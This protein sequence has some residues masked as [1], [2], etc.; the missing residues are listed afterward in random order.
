MTKTQTNAQFNFRKV[1][2]IPL[3][4][5]VL[6]LLLLSNAMAAFTR[7]SG[8]EEPRIRQVC[9][10]PS[11]P[12]FLAVASENGLYIS[13]NGG[14][15]F[16]KKAVF[17]DETIN[18]LFLSSGMEP[19]VY[20]AGSRNGYKVESS[21]KRIFTAKENEELYFIAGYNGFLYAGT[22][23]GLYF[24][25]E[26]PINWQ[27]LPA[28]GNHAVYSM[29]DSGNE[30]Y[31]ACDDG[32]YLYR[33]DHTLIRLFSPPGN[34]EEEARIPHQITIDTMTPSRLWLCTG[35]GV[36]SSVDRGRTW[37]KF[38]IDGAGSGAAAYCLSQFPLDGNH[39]YLCS[40]AGFLKVNISSGESRALYEGLPTSNIRW[41]DL[42][43]S[44]VIYLAT[45]QGLYEQNHEIPE[46][47]NPVEELADLLKNEPS[48]QEVQDAAMRYNSVHPDKTGNWR[49]RIKYRALL[50]R[51]S[52]DYDKTIGSSFTQSG[53]YYAEGPYD[54][55]VTLTW[56]MGDLIWNSYEDDIDNRTKLTTQLRMDILDEVNRLYFERLRLKHE[57][58][59][60][61]S[62]TEDTVTKELR[63]YELTA[64]LD[65][66]T[67][68]LYS[69]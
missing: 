61:K 67:G 30:I 27:S 44:G 24:S 43:P 14:R 41:V 11:N 40:A 45:D 6:L 64:T 31:L 60:G 19:I 62:K 8:I 15:D 20:V 2:S 37:R 52:L 53:Y 13:N 46:Q 39:F 63:L 5:P 7:I 56:D 42:S 25:R 4:V 57:I 50:P 35:S 65:G 66:Y 69:R 36:Y 1:S 26:N 3:Y 9:I 47:H 34:N 16:Q 38:F 23:A 29:A 48:I 51:L 54:W 21:T 12:S 59:L 22:Q 17:K 10:S 33:P 32:V 68:G 18:R 55:G 58:A 49:K 28:L